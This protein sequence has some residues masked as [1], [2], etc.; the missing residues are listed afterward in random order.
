MKEK[1]KIERVVPLFHC[2]IVS[3]VISW[4]FLCVPATLR[5]ACQSVRVPLWH[6]FRRM[7]DSQM[8]KCHVSWIKTIINKSNCELI[9]WAL[10]NC[11]LFDHFSGPRHTKW[12]CH[13]YVFA[14]RFRSNFKCDFSDGLPYIDSQL[15]QYQSKIVSNRFLSYSALSTHRQLRWSKI[16]SLVHCAN[17]REAV[18]FN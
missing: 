6:N 15:S 12:I 13:R 14:H 1:R 10:Q 8:D 17:Y 3:E 7:C 18:D 9:V 2:V 4:F 11:I 16:F 5:V